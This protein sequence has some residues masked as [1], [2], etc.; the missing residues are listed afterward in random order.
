[1]SMTNK[2]NNPQT[3]GNI[4]HAAIRRGEDPGY[5]AYLADQWERRQK[6]QPK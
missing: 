1:M 6:P 4:Y 3:W 2:P 5:A